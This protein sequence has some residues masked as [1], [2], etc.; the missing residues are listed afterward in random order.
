MLIVWGEYAVIYLTVGRSNLRAL[1]MQVLI[2][3]W[4]GEGVLMTKSK[5]PS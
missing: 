3:M 5:Y 4:S 1:E 2:R